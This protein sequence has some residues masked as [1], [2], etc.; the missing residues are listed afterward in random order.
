[1]AL[2][3]TAANAGVYPGIR[4]I[5]RYAGDTLSTMQTE[6]ILQSSSGSQTTNLSRWG[7]YSAMTVDPVDDC[8]FWYTQEYMDKPNGPFWK[9]RIANAKFPDCR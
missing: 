2:G 8:T 6:T 7:D 4:Y 5:G 1:M 3:Y 9:T